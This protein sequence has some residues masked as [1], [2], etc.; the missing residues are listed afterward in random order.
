[1]R[2]SS[3]QGERGITRPEQPPPLVLVVDDD[4]DALE[5]MCGFLEAAE[6]RIA[7]AADGRQAL[8]RIHELHPA[9][10]VLD[11]MLPVLSGGRVLAALQAE[12]NTVPVVLVSGVV[13]IP[14]LGGARIDFLP[15]P[16]APDSLREAVARAVARSMPSTMKH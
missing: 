4:P 5:T 15:K 6:Y 9:A 14:A 7:R 13:K 11:L 2:T 3:S 8:E 16:C 10:V 12:R 1:M